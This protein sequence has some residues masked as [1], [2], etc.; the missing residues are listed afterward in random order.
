MKNATLIKSF[1]IT[2]DTGEKK[3]FQ[4]YLFCQDDDRFEIF[5]LTDKM[6]FVSTTFIATACSDILYQSKRIGELCWTPFVSG[7]K[8]TIAFKQEGKEHFDTGIPVDHMEAYLLAEIEI[9]K[10]LVQQ[11]T[12]T[13]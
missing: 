10:H 9:F 11:K 6:E 2:T 1:F 5:E 3:H 12:I 4:G 8:Q 7:K 13:L